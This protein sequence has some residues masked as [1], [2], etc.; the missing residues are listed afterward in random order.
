MA[1]GTPAGTPARVAED[2]AAEAAAGTGT[3]MGAAAEAAAGSTVARAPSGS[4][5]GEWAVQMAGSATLLTAGTAS[6]SGSFTPAT[7][8]TLRTGA[9]PSE[10]CVIDAPG[11]CWRGDVTHA[12]CGA[13]DGPANGDERSLTLWPQA[14]G[15][16]ASAERVKAVASLACT[17]QT[18]NDVSAPTPAVLMSDATLAP[19]PI[20]PKG[21]VPIAVRRSCQGSVTKPFG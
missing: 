19:E 3:G 15:S 20:P 6:V 10:P 21:C 4:P 16:S 14:P 1:P 5:V 8:S 18:R 12:A 11:A 13:T 2:G 17:P 7:L 9:P